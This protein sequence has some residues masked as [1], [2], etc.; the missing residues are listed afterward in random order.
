MEKDYFI[1]R[2][3][4]IKKHNQADIHFHNT[5]LV[6]FIFECAIKNFIAKQIQ[7]NK[8]KTQGNIKYSR[9]QS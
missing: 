8:K 3:S 6:F 5:S 9:N 2:L 7:V 1:N 4:F